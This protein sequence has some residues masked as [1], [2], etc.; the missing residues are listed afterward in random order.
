VRAF[1]F[2][3]A[4]S[5]V[6]AGRVASAQ[7]FD[8]ERC[9]LIIE[10][11]LKSDFTDQAWRLKDKN[12]Y[13]VLIF[14]RDNA[15]VDLLDKYLTQRGYF[16]AAMNPDDP[17]SKHLLAY[18]SEGDDDHRRQM[19]SPEVVSR[20]ACEAAYLSGAQLKY[21]HIISGMAPTFTVEPN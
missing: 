4:L 8:P 10:T 11:R 12:Y 13:P 14:E 15:N 18:S 9:R 21:V 7:A 1:Y 20:A 2:S 16:T 19:A 5:A 17:Q 6:I 3:I